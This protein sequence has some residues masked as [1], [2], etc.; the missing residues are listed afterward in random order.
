MVKMKIRERVRERETVRE[1]ER[2]RE[3]TMAQRVA[4]AA[5]T[6]KGPRTDCQSRTLQGRSCDKEKERLM[7]M[8]NEHTTPRG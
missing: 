6:A 8:I 1:R 7:M 3:G 4:K 2:E 5:C